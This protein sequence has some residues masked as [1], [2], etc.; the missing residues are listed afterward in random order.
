MANK[1]RIKQARKIAG[2]SLNDL[3]KKICGISRQALHKYETGIVIPDRD[4]ICKI[5]IAT[6]MNEDFFYKEDCNVK[7]QELK[8]STPIDCNKYYR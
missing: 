2:L 3:A 4:M 1:N 6:G 5:S 8:F 7:L